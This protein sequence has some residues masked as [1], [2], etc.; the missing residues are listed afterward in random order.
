MRTYTLAERCMLLLFALLDGEKPL[1]PRDY[2]SLGRM[3]EALGASCESPD[4]ELTEAELIRLGQTREEAAAILRRLQRGDLL[5]K[6]L[7]TLRRLG[8]TVLTRIS[9]E[10]PR[11]L[12]Q[13]LGQKAPMLL[14]CAGNLDLFGTRCVSLVG[15]RQL[16]EPGRRFAAAVGTAAAQQGLSYVSGGAAGADT[17]GF[18]AAVEAGGSAIVFL[19]DSLHLRAAQMAEEQKTGRVLLVSQGGYDLPFSIARAYARNDLIHAMGEQVFVA[20]SDYGTGGTWQGVTENLRHGWSPVYVCGSEPEDPGT[21]GLL[22]RGCTPVSL[23][24]LQDLRAIAADQTSL[25]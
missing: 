7:D 21:R 20:Q 16:R 3:L 18:E 2:Q 24:D 11:R 9:P 17:V 19:A 10:Y 22:E 25:L 5:E 23:E 14:Y 6:H 1:R 8:L 13:T 15:S 4:A 12:R